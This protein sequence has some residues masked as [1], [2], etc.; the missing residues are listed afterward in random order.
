MATDNGRANDGQK[1]K[2]TDVNTTNI[3]A[4]NGDNGNPK[5]Q[6][7]D[8]VTDSQSPIAQT[9]GSTTQMSDNIHDNVDDDTDDSTDDDTKASTT[10]L[11]EKALDLHEKIQQRRVL[12]IWSIVAA[13]LVV[14]IVIAGCYAFWFSRH[15]E[16]RDYQ[17]LQALAQK[18]KGMTKQGGL[19]AFKA[20]D[21]NPKAPSV[22]LYVDF[23]CPGCATVE[24]GLSTPLEKMQEARQINLYIHPLNFLDSKTENKYSTRSASA[25]AYI[26]SQE[27]DKSLALSTA[28]FE[29]GYQP[30]KNNNRNVSNQEIIEQA[31]KAGVSK[32][33]A[34][35]STKGTYNDYVDKATKYTT[36]RKELYV[37]MQDNF[38]F[39]TPTICINGTMWPYR[40]LHVIQDIEP[41]LVH[42][43][44]L[45]REQVGDAKIT[46]SIG[47][48]GKALA[49]QQKY[50]S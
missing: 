33:V 9:N 31:L 43:L 20:S 18:P 49:I 35:N 41:T 36:E 42:S 11:K 16:E 27:P 30:N 37:Q 46:P 26:A 7:T 21:Y 15:G 8:E 19:P 6:R 34:E 22:D 40:H 47:S 24:K 25:F 2:T 38:R 39:S 32:T 10:L 50:L 13:V 17:Q 48:D 5:S 28:L 23:F 12:V 44:G 29:K 4:N 1:P 3:N 45:H 14:I